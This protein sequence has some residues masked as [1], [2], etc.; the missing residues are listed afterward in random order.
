MCCVRCLFRFQVVG[1]VA[2]GVSVQADAE[3]CQNAVYWTTDCSAR[4]L[5]LNHQPFLP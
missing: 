4:V 2:A 3:G 1:E 5:P